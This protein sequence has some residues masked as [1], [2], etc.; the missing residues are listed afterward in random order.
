MPLI[1]GQ[2]NIYALFMA[3]A[4]A[5]LKNKGETVFIMPRGFC[6]GLYYKGRP[7]LKSWSPAYPRLAAAPQPYKFPA[8]RAKPGD[9]TPAHLGQ[10]DHPGNLSIFRDDSQSK[11]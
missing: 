9:G 8:L 6:S 5:M 2:L 7:P 10:N 4:S 1:S 11:Q 3:M